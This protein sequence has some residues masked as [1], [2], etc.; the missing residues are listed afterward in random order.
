MR[1]YIGAASG[2]GSRTGRI[3]RCRQ[4]TYRVGQVVRS[5]RFWRKGRGLGLKLELLNGGLNLLL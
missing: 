4:E 5:M 3:L 1:G 2:R